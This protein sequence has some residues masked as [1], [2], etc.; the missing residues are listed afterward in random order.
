[1][2]N[3]SSS[4]L[5]H[6]SSRLVLAIAVALDTNG[7]NTVYISNPDVIYTKQRRTHDISWKLT[8]ISCLITESYYSL[9]GQIILIFILMSAASNGHK[10]RIQIQQCESQNDIST[11]PLVATNS[12]ALTQQPS[13]T[14][15]TEMTRNI[16][17][18]STR[19][20]V[21]IFYL[22]LSSELQYV[23]QV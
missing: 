7:L 13:T 5:I 9:T 23:R 20:L 11:H 21:I 10:S 3:R 1:M 18:V 4:F 8:V 15:E 2:N 19:D 16:E 6:R 22:S 17:S 12:A 14:I